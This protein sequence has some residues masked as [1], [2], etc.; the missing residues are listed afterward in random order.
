MPAVWGC[1]EGS[2]RQAGPVGAQAI[3]GVFPLPQVHRHKAVLPAG[4]GL[5]PLPS[6]GCVRHCLTMAIDVTQIV[7]PVRNALSPV[8]AS[9]SEAWSAVIGDR[10]AAWRLK[11]AAQ[12]Q[13]A[14][15]AEVA[16]LGLKLDRSKIPERYAFA[17]FEEATKQ[18]EPEIQKLFARLLARAAAGDEEAADRRHLEILTR[19]TPMDA[20]V[21]DWLFQNGGDPHRHAGMVEYEAWSRLRREVGEAASLSLEH[22]IALG[23]FERLYSIKG[24]ESPFAREPSDSLEVH[25]ELSATE[26]GVSLYRAC[27]A[28]PPAEANRN[29]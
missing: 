6:R 27:G 17:W 1:H 18:D 16:K 5:T 28:H 22:L 14:V 10:I 29:G 25:A 24:V 21:M 7:E 3:L 9:L 23:V 12:L 19:L 8:G 4:G 26:R 15:N 2:H 20:R 13:T 11:N